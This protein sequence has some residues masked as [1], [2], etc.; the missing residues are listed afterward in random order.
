MA[1]PVRAEVGVGV[2]VEVGVVVV[3]G[4][5]V[6]VVVGVVK[7]FRRNKKMTRTIEVSDETFEKIKGEL[8]E[9]EKMDISEY[10]DIV[11]QKL[12]IRTVTYHL[13]GKVEKL[14]G[15]FFQLKDAS[16]V[17]DSGRFM[18]AIKEGKLNEVE[19]VGMAFVN[20]ESVTDFF[21]WKHELPKEQK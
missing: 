7:F 13:V 19:P 15:K 1:A 17:A 10:E 2:E 18:N 20:I 21:P 12:Y 11:G 5:E 3:V 14:I 4:V 6:E 16:W 9:E 8:K